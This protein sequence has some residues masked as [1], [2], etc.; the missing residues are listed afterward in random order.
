MRISPARPSISVLSLDD[1][2]KLAGE[3]IGRCMELRRS[4]GYLQVT[5][6]MEGARTDQSLPTT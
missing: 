2:A 4:E 6:I 3:Q 1:Y 5:G